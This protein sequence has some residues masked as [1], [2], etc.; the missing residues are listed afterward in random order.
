MDWFDDLVVP[1]ASIAGLPVDQFKFVVFILLSYP[2]GFLHLKYVNLFVHS[3]PY[4]QDFFEC[5]LS[6]FIRNSNW[7][8][9]PH[10]FIWVYRNISFLVEFI[11]GLRVS[12]A[13]GP[14]QGADDW[15]C[16]DDGILIVSPHFSPLLRL[17]GLEN[18]CHR[19]AAFT[20][21]LTSP[22]C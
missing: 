4:S 18:G 3:C 2:L 13:L 7:I 22:D 5:T 20:I 8:H 16:R 15:I 17:Y 11:S 1:Y 19:Y 12:V 10:P 14:Q 21:Q 9:I 6:P